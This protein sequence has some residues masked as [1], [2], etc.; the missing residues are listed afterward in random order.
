VSIGRTGPAA[1]H[2]AALE[3][4]LFASVKLHGCLESWAGVVHT[5]LSIGQYDNVVHGALKT[6]DLSDL[7]KTL[8]KEKVTWSDPVGAQGQPLWK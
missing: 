3:P 2:A 6:Y 4:Q 1:L 8:P 5:P 7:L